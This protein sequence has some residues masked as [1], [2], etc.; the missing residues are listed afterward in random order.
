MFL[1]FSLGSSRS[2]ATHRRSAV[3]TAVL[4]LLALTANS[5]ALD[6]LVNQVGYETN[7]P[8]VFRVQRTADYAGDGTFAIRRVS[9]NA[10][11]F[12]GTLT[13]RGRS[14][15]QVLLGGRLQLVQGG[16]R[17]LRLRHGQRRERVLPTTSPWATASWSTRRESPRTSI[18]RP[19]AAVPACLFS[20]WIARA[21]WS[22]GPTTRATRTTAI[23]TRAAR[24]WMGSGG[25]HDC[26]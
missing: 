24:R 13:R 9:D 19:N 11:V 17:L 7:S 10:D 22:P 5:W 4:C 21:N 1:N 16:R 20:T 8:K 3:L 2:Y 6:V 15:E 26:R 12:T 25:W 23:S 18:S 14:L